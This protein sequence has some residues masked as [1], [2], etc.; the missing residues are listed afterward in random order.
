[1]TDALMAQTEK[2]LGCQLANLHVVGG[3][4][5]TFNALELPVDQ[6]NA[7][8][9]ANGATVEFRIRRRSGR[10]EN[11]SVSARQQRFDLCLFVGDFF[12]GTANQILVTEGFGD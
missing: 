2:V 8:A 11:Q 6:N 10:G 7:R 1:M 5:G 3:D 12:I 9:V 4:G